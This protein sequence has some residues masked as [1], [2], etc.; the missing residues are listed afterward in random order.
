MVKRSDTSSAGSGQALRLP[1]YGL[2]PFVLP[3]LGRQIGPEKG[4]ALLAMGSEHEPLSSARK[5]P[6][7]RSGSVL[8]MKVGERVSR[9]Y[10]VRNCSATSWKIWMVRWMSS[11][12]CAIPM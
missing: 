6:A 10:Y 9:G 5:K 7:I 4:R 11:S 1:T 8:V 12:E 2:G 3:H